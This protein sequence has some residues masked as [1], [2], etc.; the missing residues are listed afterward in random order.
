MKRRDMLK[1]T[2]LGATAAFFGLTG[3]GEGASSEEPAK[4][5]KA[6]GPLKIT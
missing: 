5:S 2:G 4:A 6:L 1:G 3:Y